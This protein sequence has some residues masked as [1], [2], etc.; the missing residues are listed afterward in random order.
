MS[1][2]NSPQG[3]T[4]SNASESHN[5]LT[6][7]IAAVGFCLVWIIPSAHAENWV[8]VV[9]SPGEER[10]FLDVDVDSILKGDDGLVYYRTQE[11]MGISPTA[12]D[13]QQRVYYVI[14]DGSRDWRSNGYPIEPGSETA[15]EADFVC[16][17]V[18]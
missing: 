6:K 16:S 12:V 7:V 3:G 5:R 18:A 1:K 4:F 10:S 14:G 17:R 8:R 2:L 15:Q 9:S 13:C 11:D